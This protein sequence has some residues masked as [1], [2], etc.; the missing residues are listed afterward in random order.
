MHFPDGA[1]REIR[2][3][4]EQVHGDGYMRGMHDH[5]RGFHEEAIWKDAARVSRESI[6]RVEPELKMALREIG[7]AGYDRGFG[8]AEAGRGKT[9]GWPGRSPADR[10]PGM[11][12]STCSQ[13]WRP[14]RMSGDSTTTSAERVGRTPPAGGWAWTTSRR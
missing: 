12:Q 6:L 1:A 10:G 2:F 8:D 13:T 4:L 3:V 11:R 14:G 9:P 5:Q 7:A